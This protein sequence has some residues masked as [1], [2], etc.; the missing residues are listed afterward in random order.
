MKCISNFKCVNQPTSLAVNEQPTVWPCGTDKNCF[1]KDHYQFT[2][3]T[4]VDFA[5]SEA[6][7]RVTVLELKKG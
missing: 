4:C 3:E 2:Q 1:L 5:C 6:G 7:R